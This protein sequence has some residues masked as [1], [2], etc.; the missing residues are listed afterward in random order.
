[1]CLKS[2]EEYEENLGVIFNVCC[3]MVFNLI[4]KV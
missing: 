4:F 2:M 1:M 3:I